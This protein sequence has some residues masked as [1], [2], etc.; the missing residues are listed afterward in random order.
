[1]SAGFTPGPWRLDR[2]MNEYG[3]KDAPILGTIMAEDAEAPSGLG[4]HVAV[5]MS[6]LSEGEANARLIAAAPEL[7]EELE[8]AVSYGWHHQPAL[9][10]IAKARGEA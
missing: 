6:D 9:D 3:A 1:M 2:R 5:V 10:A 4:W 7:L 8:R